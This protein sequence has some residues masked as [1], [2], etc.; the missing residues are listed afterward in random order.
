MIT[1]LPGCTPMKP[2]SATLPFFGVIPAV[3]DPNGRELEGEC[4]GQLVFSKPW[5]GIARTIDG[6]H[7]WFEMTYFHKF[8]GYYWTGDGVRRD[9]DGYYWITG[10]SDDTLNVSGHLLSTAEIETAIVEHRAVAEAA[11]VSAPHSVKGEVL[12]VFVVLNNEFQFSN[13]L[14]MDIKLRGKCLL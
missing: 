13:D 9:S 14:E 10:R 12:Y 2:G 1:S 8:R 4:E 3:L 5:P 11:A 6:K 7:E